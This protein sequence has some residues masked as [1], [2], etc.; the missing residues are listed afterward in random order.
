MYATDNSAEEQDFLSLRLYNCVL[1]CTNALKRILAASTCKNKILF[2]K[3]KLGQ[4]LSWLGSCC[5]CCFA[6]LVFLGVCVCASV[7]VQLQLK[8]A[9][10]DLGVHRF[11]VEFRQGA[12]CIEFCHSPAEFCT[13]LPKFMSLMPRQ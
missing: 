9:K 2:W 12:F 7:C 10:L 3:S 6:C 4:C 13:L 1:F 11:L 8:P 5:Y